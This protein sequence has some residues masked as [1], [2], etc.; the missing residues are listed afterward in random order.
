MIIPPLEQFQASYTVSTP[1]SGFVTNVINV[2]APDSA[3]GSTSIGG[4]NIPASEFTPIG[5]TGFSGAQVEVPLGTHNLGGTQPFGVFSYGFG[6]FDSYGYAGGQS[7]AAIANVVSISVE[8][9]TQK[10]V[11]NTPG[12]VTATP[13]D[14]QGV[15]VPGVRVDFAVTGVNTESG[16]GVAD[17]NGKALFCYA[18]KNLGEDTITASVGPLKGTAKKTWVLSLGQCVGKEVTT[19]GSGTIL[20]SE[21]ADVISGAETNDTITGLGGDD[22]I[23]GRGGDDKVSGDDGKDTLR[24]GKKKDK[25]EGGDGNDSIRGQTGKDR[26]GGG[27][28]NDKLV[29]NKGADRLAGNDGNDK[30]DADNGNDSLFG[31]PGNDKLDGGKGDNKCFPD[32]GENKVKNCD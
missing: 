29:A 19:D 27:E 26:L 11:I 7:F 30:L 32:G 13:K 6:S 8:P 22:T 9:P 25:V 18:G 23:C 5:S 3:V 2:V 28:G 31:G 4:G 14:S 1:A 20:G 24:G 10:H 12:C 17:N 16:F 21:S 15:G